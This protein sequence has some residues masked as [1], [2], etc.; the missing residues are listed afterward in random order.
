MYLNID[1]C[2]NKRKKKM[3]VEAFDE[4]GSNDGGPAWPNR[5][6]FLKLIV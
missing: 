3:V 2:M 4:L 5:S 1:A 6:N